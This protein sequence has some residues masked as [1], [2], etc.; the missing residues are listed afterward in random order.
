MIAEMYSEGLSFRKA[1]LSVIAQCE[2]T[3]FSEFDNS[4]RIKKMFSFL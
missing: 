4:I 1:V 2:A 3:I